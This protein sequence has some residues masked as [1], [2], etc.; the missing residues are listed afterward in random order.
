MCGVRGE[1]GGT[2]EES[3]VI[4]SHREIW[5]WDVETGMWPCASVL[6]YI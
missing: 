5:S 4:R 6:V 3:A 2:N 1:S